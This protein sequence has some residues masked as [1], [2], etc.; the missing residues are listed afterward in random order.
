M[1]QLTFIL[2]ILLFSIIELNAQDYQTVKSGRIT[3]FSNEEGNIKCIKIDSVQFQGD[4]ILFPSLNI[5]Q[6]DYNC[7]APYGD[8]WIGKKVIIQANGYNLFI[9][10]YDDT[11]RIK[12]NAEIRESWTAYELE[13]SIL[14][15]A[16]VKGIDTLAFLGLLDSVKTI[17]FKVYDKDSMPISH[18]LN[19]QQI[20][21][22]KKYGFVRMLNFSLFPNG[23]PERYYEQFESFNLIGFSNPFI[24]VQNL[25]WLEVFDFKV[26]DELHSLDKWSRWEPENGRGYLT[27]RKTKLKY[28]E[29]LDSKDSIVYRI[30]REESVFRRIEKWDSTTYV[31]VHDTIRAI[32]KPDSLFDQLPGAPI[33]SEFDAYAYKMINAKQISK[34]KPSGCEVIRPSTDSCWHYPIAD[35]CSSEFTY[36]KGLGGPY[37]SCSYSV[38]ESSENK[39]VYYKKGSTTWGTPLDLTDSKRIEN[40]DQIKIYPNPARD[41]VTIENTTG[42]PEQYVLQLLDMEG[43][44]V[45]N[46]NIEFST[47]YRV[48]LTGLA[49]GAYVL[50]LQY[51]EKQLSK[52]IIRQP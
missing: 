15:V 12:T 10:K 48:D 23:D 31:F 36:M 32:Y 20:M 5:Q 13:D 19:E 3:Y 42:Q 29:R 39:L 38:T 40:V 44:Q 24:G 45:Y 18:F 22:S 35:G 21:V 43:R 37:Y 8:S 1:K 52:L 11:I 47:T 28:L 26:G 33:V 6:L 27:T 51:G 46:K 49:H 16:E 4:S 2:A 34:V 25:T 50:K 14:V 7:F 30:D 41:F 17:G 9:N